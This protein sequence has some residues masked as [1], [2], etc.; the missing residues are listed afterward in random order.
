MRLASYSD[1]SGG[2]QAEV[3]KGA[4]IDATNDRI[5][6]NNAHV[7]GGQSRPDPLEY[8]GH[9]SYFIFAEPPLKCAGTF[10]DLTT[11]PIRLGCRARTRAIHQPLLRPEVQ[12]AARS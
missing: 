2:T 3:L 7:Q 10:A 8:S 4:V 11:L 1:N 6:Q 9:Q 12:I 5:T